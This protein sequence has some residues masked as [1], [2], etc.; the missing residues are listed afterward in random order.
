MTSDMLAERARGLP[1]ES[2]LEI[3]SYI[4]FLKFRIQI[5]GNRMGIHENVKD[6][7]KR[8]GI[9]KGEVLY[10]PEYNIDEEDVD[11]LNIFEV[12]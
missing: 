8:I 3:A 10:D 4:D 5:V 6:V 7:S 2:I 9:A 1:E 12:L 11:F